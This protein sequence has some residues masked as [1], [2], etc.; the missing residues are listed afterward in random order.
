MV[1]TIFV[2]R[3]VSSV[4]ASTFARLIEPPRRWSMADEAPRT[5]EEVE[6][7]GGGAA[8]AAAAAVAAAAAAA[9]TTAPAERGEVEA[10]DEV[11]EEVE[12]LRGSV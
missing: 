12:T 6:E 8:A 1:Q 3:F 9:G 10:E 5:Y 11:E 7:G 4:G 2:L